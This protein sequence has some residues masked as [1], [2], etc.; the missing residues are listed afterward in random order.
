MIG[1]APVVDV[2]YM[3][4]FDYTE[5]TLHSVLVEVSQWAESFKQRK[6]DAYKEYF[7]K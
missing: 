4:S 7:P 3:K 1:D 2:N 6:A 5:K